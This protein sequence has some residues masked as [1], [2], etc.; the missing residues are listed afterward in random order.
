[1]RQ[2]GTG[3]RGHGHVIDSMACAARHFGGRGGQTLAAR[4]RRKK[5]DTGARRHHRLAVG[6]TRES[7]STVRERE[8]YSVVTHTKAI[9]HVG[10][11]GHGDLDSAASGVDDFDTERL[12]ST[13]GEV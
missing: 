3:G 12:R 6:I 11:H 1:M 4:S 5:L 8:H 10:T 2:Y 13:V 7:E 9:D